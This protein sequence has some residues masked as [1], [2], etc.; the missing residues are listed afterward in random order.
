MVI[1]SADPETGTITIL[2]RAFI[3]EVWREEFVRVIDWRRSRAER[4]M[5]AG[6][7]QSD[8]VYET[9]EAAVGACQISE[10]QARHL[11]PDDLDGGR[12]FFF[13]SRLRYDRVVVDHQSRYVETAVS[14]PEDSSDHED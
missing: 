2:R 10:R 14:E 11:Y 9:A 7:Y 1:E 8:F 4:P 12:Q 13:V 3:L 5:L 6:R